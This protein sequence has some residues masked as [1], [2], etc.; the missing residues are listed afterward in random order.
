MCRKVYLDDQSITYIPFYGI[1]VIIRSRR[2]AMKIIKLSIHNLYMF[3]DFEIDFTHPRKVN[4]V[5]RPFEKNEVS[6]I[7]VNDINIFIGANAT[8]KTALGKC[9]LIIQTLIKGYS[10][11]QYTS[12]INYL[13]ESARVSIEYLVSEGGRDYFFKYYVEFSKKRILN[14]SLLS[15]H[16]TKGMSYNN[17]LYK[18][19]V[20]Y[21]NV[22]KKD[23]DVDD[24]I[25]QSQIFTTY[26]QEI[27]NKKNI[28]FLVSMASRIG[29][30]YQYSGS[31]MNSIK[32]CGESNHK[33][34]H[35]IE[36]FMKQVDPRIDRLE[37]LENKQDEDGISEVEFKIFFKGK[38]SGTYINLN[39]HH[40]QF[41]DLHNDLSSG[42]IEAL[43]M[44][45]KCFEIRNNNFNTVYVDEQL[46]HTHFE[47]EK[48]LLSLLMATLPKDSQLFYTSHNPEIMKMN[49]PIVFYYILYKNEDG[50]IQALRPSDYIPNKNDRDDLYEKVMSD[51]FN[52][53]ISFD[54]GDFYDEI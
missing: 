46:T 27:I 3:K 1:Y 18:E 25:V 4:N 28:Y 44:F 37:P 26:K 16:L 9:L 11:S 50:F 34:I 12:C 51:Y 52:T 20:S 48:E 36:Y 29:Y 41:Y 45:V 40:P 24:S 49:L 14:E 38:K 32:D 39:K 22:G 43:S 2:K 33:L 19:L 13:S 35:D 17:N 42:S 15:F 10:I 21:V 54:F 5:Y 53:S 6:N 23:M 8:G 47:L 7:N 31:V 30:T